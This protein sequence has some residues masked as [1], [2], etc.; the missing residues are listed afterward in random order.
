MKLNEAKEILKNAGF[1]FLNNVVELS[2]LN[3]RLQRLD[4]GWKFIKDE[5]NGTAHLYT[6][7]KEGVGKF[8]F[9]VKPCRK[10][11]PIRARGVA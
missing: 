4:V 3:R 9:S 2:V 11:F 10:A 8:K 5:C 1:K 7:G 6:I